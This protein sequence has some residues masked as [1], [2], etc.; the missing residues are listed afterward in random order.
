MK[1]TVVILETLRKEVAG[2][3]AD[4]EQEA[5][6]KVEEMFANSD[7]KLD[8]DEDDFD[9]RYFATEEDSDEA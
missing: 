6:S 4:S 8:V 7:I 2:I 1:Y 3:Q 5:I 9:T